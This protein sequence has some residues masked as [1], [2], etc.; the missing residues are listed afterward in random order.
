MS[1]LSKTIKTA[2]IGLQNS[3]VYKNNFFL[4]FVSGIF[5]LIVQL[6]FWPVYYNAGA[7]LSYSTIKTITIS[8]YYLDEMMTYSIIIYFVQKITS[9][10][11]VRDSIKGDI[12]TGTL[13]V[14]LIRP[15]KYLW[16]KWIFSISGQTINFVLSL[17]A[18][19]VAVISLK[20]FF[21]LPQSITQTLL[22]LLF[23]FFSCILSF[24]INCIIGMTSFWLLETQ[25]LGTLLNMTITVLSGSLFPIDLIY[26]NFK[27]ILQLLPFSYMAFIPVQIYLNK[28]SNEKILFNIVVCIVWIIILY[29]VVDKLW[30]NGI[31]RYSAFGG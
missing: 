11:N 17:L 2:E 5:G 22:V 1:T 20:K 4:S 29:V 16:S 19:L 13:N 30:K 6:V 3:I 12:M 26:N 10:M 9:M 24:F 14:H 15:V 28:I 25:A 27:Y 23:V 21:I 18:L 31:R 8:G 7:D